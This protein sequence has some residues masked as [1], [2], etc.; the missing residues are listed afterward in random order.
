M[1]QDDY[2]RTV[3]AIKDRVYSYAVYLLGDREDAKDIAQEALVRLWEHRETIPETNSARAWTLR[4]THNLAI[5]R[6]RGRHSR[7]S[8][9]DDVLAYAPDPGPGPEAQMLVRE[10]GSTIVR[11]L[12]QLSEADRAVLILRESQGLRY[13]EIANI[14]D[15]PLGTLKV[16]LHRA[17]QRLREALLAMGVQR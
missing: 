2:C 9:D 4:T 15:I 1:D 5:D 7:R 14:L 12:G 13:E 17:R 3:R 16:R 11:A 10:A 8:I 6:M